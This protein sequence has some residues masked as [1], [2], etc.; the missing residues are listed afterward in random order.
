MILVK[1]LKEIV[2]RL[3]TLMHGIDCTV[4]TETEEKGAM[5]ENKK[6]TPASL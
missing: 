1:I 6:Y 5:A 2:H 4:V 3:K